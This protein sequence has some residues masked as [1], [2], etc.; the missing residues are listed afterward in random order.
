MPPAI[1]RQSRGEAGRRPGRP[2]AQRID[3]QHAEWLGLLRPEGPF[4]TV[5]VLVEALPHG[6]DTVPEEVRNRIRQGWA[7][8][9]EA[10]DLLGPAWTELILGEL[11]N[12]PSSARSEGVAGGNGFQPELVLSGPRLGGGRAARLHVHRLPFGM[13]LTS[14]RSDRPAPVDQ[15]AQLC[16]DA[17][18]PLALVTNG[19]HWALVHARRGEATGVGVFDA[20]LWLEEPTLLRAFAT[21]LAASRVLLPPTDA[22][23]RPSTGL[24]GLFARSA[25]ALTQ[26]TTTLGDQVR[27]AVELFVAELARLDRESEG[28]LLGKVSD[29]EI[30]QGA[31]TVLMRLVFL[32]YAEEQRLLPVADPLYAQAYAASTLHGQL[33]AVRAVHG[34]EVGDRRTAAWPRLVALFAAVHGGCE[35]PDL[36]IPAHGGS[37]FDPRRFP[38]LVDAA[39]TDRV[40]FEML[41]A[42]LVLRHRGRAAEQLSYSS[43]GVE[44]IGHVYEGLLDFSCARVT[45]PYVGLLGRREPELPLAELEAAAARGDAELRVWL[46]ARCD[47]TA[48]QVAKALDTTPA[49]H[50]LAAL[51]AACDNDAELADRVRPFWGLLRTDLRELP[52]VFPAGSVLFTQ[53]G[54]RRAT[55]THYTPRELAE[56]VVRH[57]LAP[58]CFSPGPAQG[59]TD[60]GVW[61]AKTAEE[62][63]R[64]KVLD[65]AMGSGAFL[66]AACR[67]LAEVLVRAWERDG[68][69]AELSDLANGNPDREDLLLAARR[70]V[71]ARCLYGVDRDDMAVEL[72]KLSLWLVTLAKGK[73]FGFLDHALRHGDSLVGITSLDQLTAFH[74]DPET[75]RFQH[76]R[77]FGDLVG[78]L[79]RTVDKMT[80]LRD[81]IGATVVEDT[82]DAADKAAKLAEVEHLGR[83]LRLAADAVVGAALSTAARVRR[84]PWDPE[85]D[86]DDN[87]TYD[88]RLLSL[89]D[90][91]YGLLDRPDDA[92][93]AQQIRLT[94]TDWLRGSRPEPIRP[95][96]WPL[97]FPEVVNRDGFD[98]VI[99]NPPFVGGQRL[100]GAVGPDVREYLVERVG[101]G[102]RGSADLCSYFLLRNLS[103]TGQGRVGII[104]TNT[105]GQGDTREVGLDQVVDMGWTVYR[106]NKSQPWPGTASLE[107]SL[108]WVGHAADAET[109]ILDGRPVRG[110]TPSLDARSRVTGNPYRLAANADQAFIG[111]YVLGT[112]FLLEP[113]QAQ[114]LIAKDPRNEEVLFPYLNGEDL[115]GRPDCSASRWVINFHNWSLERAQQYPD[116]FA[117]VEAKV[118]PERLRNKYSVS[119]RER[120]WQYERRRPELYAAIE[121]FERVLAVARTSRTVAATFISS[122][123]IMS[124]NVVVFPSDASSMLAV[125]ASTF[126]VLWARKYSSTLKSDLQYGPSNCF[127]SFPQP[128]ITPQIGRVGAELDS[129]RR[130]VMLDLDLGLTKLYNRVHDEQ[131]TSADIRRLREIHVEIDEAVAEAYGFDL[132]LSHGFHQTRQGTRFTIDPTAQVEILDLLLELNHQRYEDEKPQQA[133]TRR[134]PRKQIRTTSRPR[135][136]QASAALEP[137]LEDG[138]FPLPDALF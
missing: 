16:R 114:A 108:L 27:Q 84:R 61:R 117:I 104:A 62:L 112:G 58:V 82:R 47:L 80:A 133:A 30:Y 51:H 52:T 45:E 105:I 134:K 87:E 102:K 17:D 32:L 19:Q 34:D 101:R 122:R 57:T 119:A 66:V 77:F 7:E 67:Y 44:Q 39:I 65:P 21:L 23:G 29:R 22:E 121:G 130:S 48:R 81:S 99:A 40:V 60:E 85:D 96:H 137:T 132:T 5:P 70:L 50:Q 31:L 91:V 118:K 90:E 15:A 59:V 86:E 28:R 54:D 38:W 9:Q 127:E 97:E 76:S 6:L 125:L 106:A 49:P 107:V 129:Y 33:G 14:G 68:L 109:P 69:P 124:E 55:G 35:H 43:L 46:V 98:A 71:A 4:L 3:E 88:D 115:N 79:E 26:I 10:P 73:P 53:F 1:P 126:H 116:C 89:N 74:L 75:G 123:Q 120:W 92:E 13:S 25:E 103:V 131:V 24:A 42:L 100:T 128:N 56:E 94:V 95:L 63:L 135:A 113:E 138:L 18:V 78:R 72:A 83:H 93:L 64:L 136:S 36:R 11:L 8:V 2:P 111:S 41:E 20:D 37:L 110:I 12:Y